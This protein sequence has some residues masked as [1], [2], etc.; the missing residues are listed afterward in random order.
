M[1]VFPMHVVLIDT[2]RRCEIPPELELQIV[3]LPCGCWELNSGP[4]QVQ[5][6]LL[7]AKP[8][9]QPCILSGAMCGDQQATLEL[10]ERS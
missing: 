4:L 1:Y 7:T 2:K 9:I 3:V 6:I 5:Q 10:V 8:C